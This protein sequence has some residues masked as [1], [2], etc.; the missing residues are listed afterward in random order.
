[1]KSGRKRATDCTLL[2]LVL[3]VFGASA[4]LAQDQGVSPLR[5]PNI[6]L[7][8]AD[9]VG[10]TDFGAYG[11]EINTP[12]IDQLAYAGTIFSNFHASPVC[13][14][15][16]AMLLTGVDSHLAGMGYL[17]EL[18][19]PEFEGHPAYRGELAPDVVTIASLLQQVG[20]HTYM[21]GKW[22][23]GHGPGALPH[24]RGFERSFALDA[25]GADNYETRPYLPVLEA[26]VWYADGKPVD[27]PDD[28]YSSRYFVD[29]TISYIDSNRG[30]N[31]PFFAYL[32]FQAVHIPI[33][34]PAEFVDRYDGVYDQGW[35]VQRQSRIDN[36][37]ALGLVPASASLSELPAGQ[38]QWDAQSPEDKAMASKS[39]A[40]NA[41][42]LEAMDHHVGRLIVYLKEMGEFDN[43]VFVVLSDNGAEPNN[44]LDRITV[45]AWLK[46]VGYSR[47]IDTLG[48]KGSFAFIGPEFASAA[49]A[50]GSF[51]KFYAG[52]GGLRV[53]LIISGAGIRPGQQ[54]DA[55]TFI[56]DVPRTILDLA[57]VDVPAQWK[58]QNIKPMSGRSIV[59]LLDGHATRIYDTTD[60]V[61]VEAG[62]GA[63]LFKGAFKLVRNAPPLGDSQWKL[64]NIAIDP[65]ETH[66]L[67]TRKPDL[68]AE[69]MSDYKVYADQV[70][71]LELPPGYE[72]LGQMASNNK[73]VLIK[74]MKAPIIVVLV[75]L[76]GLAWWIL[77]RRRIKN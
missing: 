35:Q 60:V 49:T 76:A 12:N 41:G 3:I 14:P 2:S 43:T 54:T 45:G 47:D 66:D 22:H 17:P 55:F 18:I 32:P 10:F 72:P 36:A 38:R 44:P 77:R 23:L 71:V 30:D 7:I 16:R 9:D 51:F 29:Q 70:G 46:L 73:L 4:T 15:S 13:A 37:K 21:A 63:A 40:V 42:M 62:G 31:Q 5:A 50:P 26:P 64:F 67:T 57:N 6:V 27:L 68:F 8:L 65:G 11:S 33:Q 25:T 20:Y 75:L 59:P 58:G 19:P 1:M 74:A 28:F 69:L 48:E 24:E 53:P 39:M 34:A 61:G 52:E 56:T